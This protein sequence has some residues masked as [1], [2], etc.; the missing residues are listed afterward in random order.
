VKIILRISET[1]EN[2]DE[3]KFAKQAAA[4][5]SEQRD[6]TLNHQDVGKALIEVS[7]TAAQTGLYVPTELTLLGKGLL[8]LER[9]FGCLGIAMVCFLAA[10]G[11]SGWLVLGIIWKD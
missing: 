2:F 1:A 10:L 3:V 6:Q 5:V 9:I 8:Q 11:G 7:R 4:F